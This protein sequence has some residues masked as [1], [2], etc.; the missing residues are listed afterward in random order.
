MECLTQEEMDGLKFHPEWEDGR[1]SFMWYRF[2][3]VVDRFRLLRA[4]LTWDD[5]FETV[6]DELEIRYCDPILLLELNGIGTDDPGHWETAATREI[7]ITQARA[8]EILLAPPSQL[9]IDYAE[10]FK[11]L[12]ESK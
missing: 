10:E 3:S 9:L 4:E 1:G 8:R 11:A 12:L 5:N 7:E 6:D 2:D